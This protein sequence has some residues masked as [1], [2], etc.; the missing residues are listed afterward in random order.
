M[1]LD[2][3]LKNTSSFQE[4]LI[5]QLKHPEEARAYLEV[6]LEDYEE[7]ADVNEL[8][9]AIQDVAEAQGGIEKI[10]ELGFDIRLERQETSIKQ[11]PVI[12]KV[13]A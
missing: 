12:E 7:D 8:L 2:F 10:A 4:Y 9:A 1:D 6:A 13:R 3:V 11:E 5:E